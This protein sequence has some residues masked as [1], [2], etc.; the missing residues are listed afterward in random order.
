MKKY[1]SLL[2]LTLSL[3]GCAELNSLN[4]AVGDIAGKLN[5]TIGRPTEQTNVYTQQATIYAIKTNDSIESGKDIDTLYIKI[6]RAFGFKTREEALGSSWGRQRDWVAD[7]LDERGL[8]HD[9]T[10]GVYYRMADGFEY[11]Y[12]N[13][14]L[15]KEG[16]KVRISWLVKSNSKLVGPGVKNKMLKAIK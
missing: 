6:K 10:P 8:I 9:K 12:L 7:T 3:S 14:S 15:E 5:Q 1:I 16:N 2:F 11:G 13:V 4:D